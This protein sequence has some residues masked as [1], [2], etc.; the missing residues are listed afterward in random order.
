MT[1]G[2]QLRVSLHSRTTTADAEHAAPAFAATPGQECAS[3]WPPLSY[4]FSQMPVPP[5]S[6][7]PIQ[8]KL[9]VTPAG[10]Q[11]E[12][13]ADRVAA[14]VMR[15][16]N[17]P[18][19]PGHPGPREETR[20]AL[21]QRKTSGAGTPVA[22]DL[23]AAIQNAR[24][25]GAPLAQGVRAPMEQAF[26]RS[27]GDVRVHA[28][29]KA[30]VFNRVVSARA[31]TIG[32][33][34]FFRRGEYS[35]GGGGRELI[36]H[37]LTHVVQ[38][39]GGARR[40]QMPIQRK[41]GLELELAVPIDKLG[42]ITPEDEAVLR[43]TKPDKKRL[44]ELREASDA[45]YGE[46]RAID[47]IA[48]A[49]DHSSRVLPDTQ[50]YPVR[51]FGRSIL[52]LVFK[53]A[54]ETKDEL[55]E[56]IKAAREIV[57]QIEARTDGLKKRAKLAG[58]V[59]IGPLEGKD[60]PPELSYDAMIHV[61][62]GIDPRRLTGLLSW[63]AGSA[64]KPLSEHRKVP[65]IDAL[66]VAD[67]I[68]EAFTQ[69]AKEDLQEVQYWNGIKGLTAILVLY[70]VSGADESEL[71][72]SIKN[73][74]TLLTKTRISDIIKHSLTPK[75]TEYLK[76]AWDIYKKLL[77]SL[78]RPKEDEDSPLIKRTKKGGALKDPS[79]KIKH[80]FKSGGPPLIA[81]GKEIRADDVGPKRAAADKVAGGER[82]KGMVL[83]FRSLPGRYP[84]DQWQKIAEDFFDEAE[85][86]NAMKDYKVP[87][88]VVP[89]PPVEKSVKD[90]E[91]RKIE[92]GKLPPPYIP[93]RSP[94]PSSSLRGL[95][96][97][98]MGPMR[99][100]SPPIRGGPAPLPLNPVPLLPK[101]LVGPVQGEI[102]KVTQSGQF[103]V[104]GAEVEWEGAKWKVI[105]KTGIKNY[106]LQFIG[107]L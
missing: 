36:A 97:P 88:P 73:F 26:G 43:G 42:K 82:R 60:K 27:F 58:D 105:D 17:A 100:Q 84:P 51:V 61:N 91:Q 62:I 25:G 12:Q 79:W 71:S 10:D 55:I 69:G 67:Q 4:S 89:K 44:K 9:T 41:I 19:A 68:V 13:E 57:T 80:L 6:A 87:P 86:Q 1:K 107:K 18:V 78:T 95:P 5:D 72:S 63:Y 35:P 40:S 15:R 33:D 90:V 31:F 70:L 98:P 30:D 37:E 46:F 65:I 102:R 81:E 8:P 53:P 22:P 54:V 7:P 76:D 56:S 94:S 77:I 50:T 32:R 96:P 14:E 59:Y 48:L 16:I 101:P 38:Q 29:A 47:K 104:A 103:W 106:T 85:K 24:G 66:E 93:H 34:I 39:N 45:G 99:S 64:Y 2:K 92:I 28:D 3:Q 75:E 83:E 20:G 74:A 23:A 52:E 11:Y 21:V 49:A